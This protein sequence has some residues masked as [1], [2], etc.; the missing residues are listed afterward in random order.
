MFHL[1]YLWD[2]LIKCYF[3]WFNSEIKHILF[4]H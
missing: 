3:N 2:K 1:P 4:L